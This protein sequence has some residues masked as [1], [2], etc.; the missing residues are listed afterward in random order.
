[1]NSPVARHNT[2]GGEK[3]KKDRNV[4][5]LRIEDMSS[6]K[7]ALNTEDLTKEVYSATDLDELFSKEISRKESVIK[8]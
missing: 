1:M 4:R 6:V 7:L 8:L 5:C 2:N 3:K